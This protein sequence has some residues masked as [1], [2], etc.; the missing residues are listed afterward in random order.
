MFI[1]TNKAVQT[2]IHKDSKSVQPQAKMMI[3]KT[4]KEVKHTGTTYTQ[5]QNV[6]NQYTHTRHVCTKMSVDTVQQ[7]A[8]L[9]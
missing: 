5:L 1:N 8:I 2:N 4:N 9:V 7:T 6:T 3:Q